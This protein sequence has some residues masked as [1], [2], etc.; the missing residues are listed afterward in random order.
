MLWQLLNLQEKKNAC[1]Y[2]CLISCHWMIRRE[3]EKGI[4]LLL[5]NY[6]L[7]FRILDV[8]QP[9]CSLVSSSFVCTEAFLVGIYLFVTLFPMDLGISLSS[10]YLSSS[11]TRKKQNRLLCGQSPWT[12]DRSICFEDLSNFR[13]VCHYLK[14]FNYIFKLLNDNM[15]QSKTERCWYWLRA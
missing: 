3:Q 11:S 15:T 12:K 9:S 5:I 14:K 2:A 7:G 6:D 4:S 8:H 10:W 13:L 1:V